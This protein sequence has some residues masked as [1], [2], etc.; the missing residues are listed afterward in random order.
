MTSLYEYFA[1]PDDLAAA[2]TVRSDAVSLGLPSLG[3]I[4]GID[5]AVQIGRV[6]SLLRRIDF[7]EV[8]SQP[9]WCELLTSIGPNAGPWVVTV[10]DTLLQSLAEAGQSELERTAA[11]WARSHEFS[12]NDILCLAES[13]ATFLFDLAALARTARTESRQLYCWMSS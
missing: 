7:D 3:L 11:L 9:R 4:T 2:A 12:C 5:P 6:E 10:T 13:L 8:L 1:A